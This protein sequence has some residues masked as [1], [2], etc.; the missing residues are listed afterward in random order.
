MPAAAGGGWRSQG[1]C[2]AGGLLGVWRG[3][4]REVWGLD[5]DLAGD[6]GFQRRDARVM[7][8]EMLGGLWVEEEE[9]GERGEE[10]EG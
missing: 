10:A 7:G 5:G 2:A 9:Y 6:G 4:R 8:D 1:A 3:C